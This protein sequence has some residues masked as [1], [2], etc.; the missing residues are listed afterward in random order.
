MFFIIVA[1]LPKIVV[2]FLGKYYLMS[3]CFLWRYFHRVVYNSKR[4]LQD[5]DS[6]LLYGKVLI[7]SCQGS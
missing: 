3:L 7:T 4:S 2:L 5:A 1:F 6:F